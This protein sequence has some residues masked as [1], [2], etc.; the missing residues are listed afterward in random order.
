[1]YWWFDSIR[2]FDP[3]AFHCIWKVLPCANHGHLRAYCIWNWS[4][5][6]PMIVTGYFSQMF[7]CPRN[8]EQRSAQ[9]AGT[10]LPTSSA[11]RLFGR[12]VPGDDGLLEEKSRWSS[13]VRTPFPLTGWLCRCN[14]ERL[15]RNLD[16]SAETI[17]YSLLPVVVVHNFQSILQ[18]SVIFWGAS[19]AYF[20][21]L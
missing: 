8:D 6:I 12:L 3:C 9:P 16:Q 21:S 14:A 15:C 10:W 5:T 2:Q 7:C 19:K 18:D 13:D 11:D 4:N 17:Q 20:T 1:M